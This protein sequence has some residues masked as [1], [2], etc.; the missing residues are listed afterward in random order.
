MQIQK[1]PL[2]LTPKRFW[3]R[4]RMNEIEMAIGRVIAFNNTT[5]KPMKIN[6]DWV[7]EYNEMIVELRERGL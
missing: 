5:D 6:E 4:N 3:M 2:G 7:E 1:P